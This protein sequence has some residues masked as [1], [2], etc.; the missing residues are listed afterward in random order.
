M[1]KKDYAFDKKWEVYFSPLAIGV[2][3]HLRR[4]REGQEATNRSP[5]YKDLSSNEVLSSWLKHLGQRLTETNYPRLLEFELGN[6]K[7]FG[8][9][10]NYPSFEDRYDEYQAY[11]NKREKPKIINNKKYLDYLMAIVRSEVFMNAHD[12][13][14][15]SLDR[16]VRALRH[17]K[18]LNTNSGA[19][20]FSR[21]SRNSVTQKA[22]RDA[23]SGKAYEYPAII[24][25]RSNRQKPRFVFM[26]P[27]SVNLLEMQFVQPLM[28]VVR[29]GTNL[30]F[31]AWEGFDEVENMT[32]QQF[33]ESKWDKDKFTLFVSV[34]YTK[35]DTTV[36]SWQSEILNDL[37][38][39]LFNGSSDIQASLT[40]SLKYVNE[41]PI[42]TPFG[43][44][45][46]HHGYASGSGW[47][48]PGESFISALVHKHG[49]ESLK[50]RGYRVVIDQINGDD[51]IFGI[52]SEK[53]ITDKDIEWIRTTIVK[54]M[55]DFGFD[56]NPDKQFI[57]FTTWKY[58][59]RFFDR[60]ETLNKDSGVIEGVYP[61]VLALNAAMN[62]ERFHDP[63]LWNNKMEI[64]RWIMILENCKHHPLFHDLIEFFVKGDKFKLGLD[65]PDF[66]S[67][68]SSLY[69][70]SKTLKQFIPSY[71][72]ATLN[73]GID[74][75]EVVKYLKVR[76]LKIK[77]RRGE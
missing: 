15:W 69:E 4:I 29:K 57:S 36:R 10:G 31:S 5:L 48:N 65:I 22:I 54:C 27:M 62:P 77:D 28:Q 58:L 76:R 35:M 25:A 3:G 14:P 40:K 71:N 63:K 44:D 9:Q 6:L 45:R 20:D 43:L 64:L 21:R 16:C 30:Q 60:E 68:I 72:Q 23:L 74:D 51:G 42:L 34:D 75:F 33:I 38:S 55:N 59:Q 50:I 61:T 7:K 17:D 19:P 8:P 56:A 73:R 11:F 24:G 37:I 70:S 49:S 53:P 52:E 41:I 18:K 1:S 39:P 47:T 67:D 2:P 46:R 13:R 12:L 26:F 32:Y 66:F